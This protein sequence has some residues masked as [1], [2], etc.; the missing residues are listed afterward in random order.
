MLY[1]VRLECDR[2]FAPLLET[3]LALAGIEMICRVD[4]ATGNACFECYHARRPDAAALATRLAE[5]VDG[6]AD[7]EQWRVH[8][9]ELAEHD[10]RDAWRDYFTAERV[11]PHLAVRPP[12]ESVPFEP[13]LAIVEINPGLSF[14]TGHH[15][16]TRSC[17]RFLD[18]LR[19]S[20]PSTGMLDVGCGS[21]ILAIAAAKLGYA[22]VVAVDC[23][24]QA[25]AAAR[26]NLAANGVSDRVTL[27]ACSLDAFPG[28]TA[29]DVVVANLFADA[30]VNGA[31]ALARLVAPAA[32]ARL[33]LAGMLND[34]AE[35]VS[36]AYAGEGFVVASA[37]A[38]AEWTTLCLARRPGV[39][40]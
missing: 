9:V 4:A 17:L 13:G 26:E 16:T 32:H 24:A 11:S 25:I 20:L 3:G 10:W 37:A 30:L 2:E 31:D 36:R 5:T 28:G 22:P 15:F 1:A 38:D 34:Q 23:D 7:G 39:G 19:E 27:M 35:S 21:G 14:G 40:G 8:I 29:F 12:W 18:A 6:W 33:V